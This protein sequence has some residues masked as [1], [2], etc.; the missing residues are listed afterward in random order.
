MLNGLIIFL[1][2]AVVGTGVGYV[3]LRMQLGKI[4]RVDIPSLAS[5]SGSVM[6][7]LLVGSDSRS[8]VTGD[9]VEATGKQIEGDRTGLSDTMMILH[10]D[11]KQGQAAIVSIPRDL[12]ITIAGKG[13]RDRINVAFADGGP[14]RL[15]ATIQESLGIQVNHYAE[16]DF[17]GFKNIV[18][19]VGGLNVYFDAAARDTVT[20]LDV[21]DAGCVRL[22]GFQ[23]LAY[24]R[25]RYYETY[26]A[27]RWVADESSDFGRIK[28]QQD[29]IRRMMKK[30]VS[31]GLSNPL[32]LNRL[33]SI[34]VNNLTLDKGMSTKDIVTVARRFKSLDPESVD[35]QTLPT[36]RYITPGGAD[37]QLLDEDAAQPLID[38]M[39]GKGPVQTTVRP[40]DVQV[41]VL[42]GNGGDAAASRAGI[43]LRGVG[44]EVTGTADADAFDYDETVVRHG[45]AALAKAQLLQSYLIGDSTLEEDDALGTADVAVV[46][47]A[48]YGGVR[49]S[50]A[51]PDARGA[52]A[53]PTTAAAQNPQP[54]ARGS[55]QPAC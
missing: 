6:N 54:D 12:Y 45:P 18:D 41:R 42:N 40:A 28:R 32:T 39:N 31:S 11:P 46:L 34:G 24:V 27:G 20:G 38:R 29:F 23:A 2:L 33:I 3:Y 55:K 25:S 10:I 26:E 22:D 1:I 35:M 7:V 13:Y 36:T 8:N 15:I 19:T 9:L 30:A 47:G 37:V 52:Q 53:P 48:T 17:E 4:K 5:D 49:P 14:Q 16:V 21:P 44:F 50:P 43:A 51:G